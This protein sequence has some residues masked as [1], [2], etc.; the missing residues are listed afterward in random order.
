[1][2]RT[3]KELT[4]HQKGRL[5][6]LFNR[7][8]KQGVLTRETGESLRRKGYVYPIG[9]NGFGNQVYKLELAGI[10]YCQTGKQIGE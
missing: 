10:R 9:S 1:M 6:W 3:E 8:N 2:P 5:V 7:P 4:L